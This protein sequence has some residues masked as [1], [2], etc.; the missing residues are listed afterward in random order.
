MAQGEPATQADIERLEA[1][2]ETLATKQSV[3][4]LEGKVDRIEGNLDVVAQQ[5][6]ILTTDVAE[7]KRTMATQEDVARHT[8]ASAQDIHRAI[9]AL[10]DK[11]QDVLDQGKER[12]AK[13]DSRVDH[14]DDKLDEHVA[15]PNAHAR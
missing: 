14:V 15:N 3:D 5:V 12:V 9:L 11:L 2:I 1:R 10:G 6:A 7:I 8:R 13:V 4:K